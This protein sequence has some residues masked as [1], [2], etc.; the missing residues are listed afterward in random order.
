MTHTS[1][2]AF[3]SYLATSGRT[4]TTLHRRRLPAESDLLTVRTTACA[5]CERTKSLAFAFCKVT[6]YYLI[7]SGMLVTVKS[8]RVDTIS[9]ILEDSGPKFDLKAPA[10]GRAAEALVF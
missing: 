3:S 10:E 6:S 4:G 1:A 7:D 5:L 8:L 9:K 2:R